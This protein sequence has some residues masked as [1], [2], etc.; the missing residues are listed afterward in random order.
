M[1]R[2]LHNVITESFSHVIP[3]EHAQVMMLQRLI[4]YLIRQYRKFIH[5]RTT[6]NNSR[7]NLPLAHPRRRGENINS[8]ELEND[9]DSGS[10]D[11]FE[12]VVCRLSLKGS[13][14]SKV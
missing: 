3:Y 13:V 4:A 14:L 5:P 9:T 7:R 10:V 12:V 11:R 6:T 8:S 1:Q 2:L